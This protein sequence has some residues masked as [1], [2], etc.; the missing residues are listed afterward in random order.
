MLPLE[1]AA[2]PTETKHFCREEKRI[3]SSDDDYLRGVQTTAVGTGQ[4][5][6]AIS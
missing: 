3:T 1:P 2:V 5:S 4:C 6:F